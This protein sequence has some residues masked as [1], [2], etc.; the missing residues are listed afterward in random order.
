MNSSILSLPVE[1]L[2]Q[3]FNI[4]L[5]LDS[6]PDVGGL[7]AFYP[8]D[9][10]Q[11][12]QLFQETIPASINHRLTTVL[13]V[14]RRWKDVAEAA[15]SLWTT[16]VIKRLPLTAVDG[17]RRY[18][19][20]SQTLPVSLYL[21][22][23]SEVDDEDI[24]G[25]NN[26]AVQQNL[27]ELRPRLRILH[28]VSRHV[29]FPLDTTFFV[30]EEDC[31]FPF[32]EVLR[33]RFP[34]IALH[35]LP[36]SIDAPKLRTL[37]CTRPFGWPYFDR[38]T[39]QTYY[40]LKR[41]LISADANGE[42]NSDYLF[43]LLWKCRNLCQLGFSG[44]VS[45]ADNEEPFPLLKNPW[46]YIQA[47]DLTG[48]RASWLDEFPFLTL[49][50]SI[51]TLSYNVTE[52]GGMRWTDSFN[53]QNVNFLSENLQQLNLC[54]IG[55]FV[56]KQNGDVPLASPHLTA[57]FPRLQVLEIRRSML[58]DNFWKYLMPLDSDVPLPMPSLS[59][60]ILKGCNFS[61]FHL[62]TAISSCHDRQWI[63]ALKIL[64][65]GGVLG[66]EPAYHRII[67]FRPL[68]LQNVTWVKDSNDLTG[69]IVIFAAYL[70]QHI[71][72]SSNS[73]VPRSHLVNCRSRS[74]MPP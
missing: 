68:D 63:A 23:S 12:V 7:I 26:V 2:C 4:V 53:F 56:L 74:T 65:L 57:Y 15:P 30:R 13:A 20:L 1:I 22:G 60:L 32:L 49:P 41:L 44:S 25:W 37:E 28:I 55:T 43:G 3:I 69:M 45:R 5:R 50:T 46:P 39:D 36:R 71:F 18:I 59:K 35:G 73:P 34:A 24:S 40:S 9:P 58:W 16:I 47:V 52:S 6:T 11:H 64:V 17:L 66:A 29:V 38:L 67:K 8:G 48:I 19:S 54:N 33:I 42:I 72:H 31:S 62:Q 70:S 21:D 51:H 10:Y 61:W 14:C 27:R